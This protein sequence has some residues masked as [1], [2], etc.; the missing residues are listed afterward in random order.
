[1][2]SVGY[3]APADEKNPPGSV[4]CSHGAGIY[5]SWEHVREWA[6]CS[7]E[8]ELALSRLK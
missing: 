5:V 2:E 1:M 4:F 3:S 7:E 6:H 8:A